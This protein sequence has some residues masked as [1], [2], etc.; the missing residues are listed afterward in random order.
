MLLLL[1]FLMAEFDEKNA[2]M[3]RVGPA[4]AIIAVGRVD[5]PTGGFVVNRAGGATTPVG[6]FVCCES[7]Y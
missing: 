1:A 3:D 5:I 4:G 7:R 2:E 6:S